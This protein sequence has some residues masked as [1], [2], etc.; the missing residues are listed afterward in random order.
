M[1]NVG[2]DDDGDDDDDDDDDNR[3]VDVVYGRRFGW[4][5]RYERV[6]G[7][8]LASPVYNMLFV[9]SLGIDVDVDV[10]VDVDDEID[11]E[12]ESFGLLSIKIITEPRQ[13]KLGI[14]V[15]KTSDVLPSSP[16][17]SNPLNLNLLFISKVSIFL[18]Y[19]FLTLESNDDPEA[20]FN[21]EFII[22][23]DINSFFVV[24]VQITL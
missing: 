13:W 17:S 23:D 22:G 3:D 19:P 21:F 10:D 9:V 2:D 6:S 20:G 1:S 7:S 11:D 5:S 18:K 4:D 8:N 14:K 15:K 24:S 16:S 12:R